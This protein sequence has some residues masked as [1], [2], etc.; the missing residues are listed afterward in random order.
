M[1][2]IRCPTAAVVHYVIG[3]Q[4]QER[5]LKIDPV[6]AA[7]ALRMRYYEQA[8]YRPEAEP[9]TPRPPLAFDDD[10]GD[11]TAAWLA[12]IEAGRIRVR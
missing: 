2:K 6:I 8:S 11:A 9:I 5:A 7:R 1:L 10:D 3:P 4:K 12:H